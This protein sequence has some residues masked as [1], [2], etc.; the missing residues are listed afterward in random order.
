MKQ[1]TTRLI[2][3]LL[4][5]LPCVAMSQDNAGGLVNGFIFDEAE[6]FLDGMARVKLNDMYGFINAQ[7][8]LTVPLIYDECGYFSD[9][10][11]R[12]KKGGKWGL[13]NKAG[14]AVVPV[15]YDDVGMFH[16]GLV[17]VQN[18]G[19]WGYVDMNGYEVIPPQYGFETYRDYVD[20]GHWDWWWDH[21]FQNGYSVVSRIE[22]GVRTD[23]LIDRNGRMVIP[24]NK[25]TALSDYSD[26][27][28]M[29][30]LPP[31]QSDVALNSA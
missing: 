1:I 8:Q 16:E 3:F 5:L 12:V 20:Y 27:M 13:V 22:D 19:K 18:D 11:A 26:G 14:V 30:L 24:F 25:F 10:F 7:G 29:A 15:R 28:I 9:G 17:S 23:G 31:A 21:E 2:L 4:T 6:N